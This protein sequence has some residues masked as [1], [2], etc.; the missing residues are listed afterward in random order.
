MGQPAHMYSALLL[1]PTRPHGAQGALRILLDECSLVLQDL[2]SIFETRYLGLAAC[3]DLRVWL[4]LCN[5]PL[6]DLREVFEH[7]ILL[8]LHTLKV[9]REIRNGFIKTG[10]LL[11]LIFFVLHLCCLR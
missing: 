6:V 7:C 4:R 1:Q 2:E 10:E 9:G 8:S 5:A 11:S 3:L